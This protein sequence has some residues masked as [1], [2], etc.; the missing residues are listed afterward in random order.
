MIEVSQPSHLMEV[1]E[2]KIPSTTKH[3]KIK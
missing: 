1:M 2:V 3:V